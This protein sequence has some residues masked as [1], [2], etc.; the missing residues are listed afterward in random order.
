MDSTYQLDTLRFKSDTELS[1]RVLPEAARGGFWGSE[2]ELPVGDRVG[3]I[4]RVSTRRLAPK[5]QV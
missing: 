2:M 3:A 5:S 4:R 1:L